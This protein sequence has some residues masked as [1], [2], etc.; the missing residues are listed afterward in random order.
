MNFW[1]YEAWGFLTVL[2]VLLIGLLVANILKRTIKPIQ[3]SLIPTS[4]LGGIIILIISTVYKV[5]TG[6][7]FF[8]TKFFATNGAAVLEII[9]YHTLALGF[10]ASAL[11]ISDKKMTGKRGVEIF[12]SGVTTVA[13]YLLQ[14][15]IG[16]AITIVG[17]LFFGWV[18]PAAGAILPMGY[19]Q[20]TG[21]AL[22]Y[23]KMYEVQNGFVGGANF[24]LTVA[25][26]GFLS[27]SIGGV[28]HLNVMKKKGRLKKVDAKDRVITLETVEHPNE[29]SMSG[30]MDKFTAQL[31]FIFIAYLLT[32]LVM[33]G[34]S[35]LLPSMQATIYG[36]NF[37]IGVLMATLIKLA[38]KG[39]TKA[40]IL[41][42]QYVN[43]FLMNRISNLCFD[44]MI[45]AG[46]AAIDL[47]LIADY[48]GMLLILGVVGLVITYLYNIFVAKTIFKDYADEQFLAMYGMLTGTASTGVMLLREVDPEY[49]TPVQDNLVY[50]TLP[51]IVF[52]FPIMFLV[53]IAPDVP[54]LV[55][56][57]CVGLFVVMNLILFRTKL[58]PKLFKSKKVES[59]QT[60]S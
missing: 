23:G 13:T 2:A 25:A 47:T 6:E 21:Q 55:L 32:Y 35:V 38:M 28:I 18:F 14:A 41:K 42:K 54:Y 57:V 10:I 29:I 30:D 31:I 53:P 36:F 45:V 15:V 37:L 34:L 8:N 5:C 33:W 39:L 43:N 48:W 24:G 59:E 9:T 26:L 16:L 19:G 1:D 11:K 60:N 49:K 7:M 52:G 56:G 44:V 20:G 50:Q 4:V 51:A 27:A 3:N 40:K 46:I 17:A 22:N 12:D 58:F